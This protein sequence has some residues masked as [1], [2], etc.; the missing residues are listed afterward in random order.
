MASQYSSFTQS[1]WSLDQTTARSAGNLT[2]VPIGVD[3]NGVAYYMENSGTTQNT[4]NKKRLSVS[5]GSLLKKPS[6][7]SRITS[8]VKM[9]FPH[10]AQSLGTNTV[11]ATA[12]VDLKISFPVYFT[13]VQRA[14]V[15]DTFLRT[16]VPQ[17]TIDT[18]TTN[19]ASLSQRFTSPTAN[20]VTEAIVTGVRP[21]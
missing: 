14:A 11:M 5:C 1:Q 13:D 19:G 15:L 8:R 18:S 9:E 21:Y 7:T 4:L 3:D 10:M 12:I 16:L 17:E 6:P 20:Q 2:W